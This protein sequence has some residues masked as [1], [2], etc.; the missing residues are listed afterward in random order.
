M[1]DGI[2]PLRTADGRFDLT[3]R[4]G[5]WHACIADEPTRWDCGDTPEAAIRAV[6][7]AHDVPGDADG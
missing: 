2:Y 4:S 1:R 5:D 3:R 6:R 7:R